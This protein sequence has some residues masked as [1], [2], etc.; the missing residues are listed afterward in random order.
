M[1]GSLYVGLSAQIAL[2]ER[3]ATIAHNV[4]NVNTPGFRAEQSKFDALVARAGDTDIAFADAGT[5][6]LSRA[7]GGLTKTDNPLDVG[8]VGEGYLAIQTPQG[9]AYTR[10]GRLFMAPSGA[11]VTVTG[12]AALDV[13][14]AP[15]LLDPTAGP[16]A[17]A[18]DGMLSQ[19]GRQIGAL[20]LFA[21]DP[22]AKLTR[23]E[24]SGV[25]PDRPATAILDFTR[26]GLVQGFVEGSNVSGVAEIS[27]L[28]AI[29]RAFDGVTAAMS[30]S[31]S[32]LA[33]AIRTLGGG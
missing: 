33:E 26:N 20:G 29:Q 23:F 9:R 4:A 8:V 1:Q 22:A 14:G 5:T 24:N 25:V 2:R 6:Y 21:I 11:L 32:N 19:Q 7:P 28:V 12:H 13:G 17:V 3:L 18:R 10:D 16:P 27:R 30:Q 31:E 15:I